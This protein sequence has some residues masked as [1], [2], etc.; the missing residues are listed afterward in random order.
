MQHYNKEFFH[1]ISAI[2]KII[3]KGLEI[4]FFKKIGNYSTILKLLLD[5]GFI[6]SFQEQDKFVIVRLK[7]TT[8]SIYIL[9]SSGRIGRKNFTVSFKELLALQRREGFSTYYILNTDKGFLSSFLAIEKG[10]G[11]KLLFKIS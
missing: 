8:K 6:S 4:L 3:T 1:F 9:K 10:V 5:E 2:S 7:V 11:G